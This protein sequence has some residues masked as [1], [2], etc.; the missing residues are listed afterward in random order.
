MTNHAWPPG[1]P[2]PAGQNMAVIPPPST[3]AAMALLA[4]TKTRMAFS[5]ER[6][7]LAFGVPTPA[8]ARTWGV[9]DYLR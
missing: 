9:R 4:L 2:R 3:L 7:S 8:E 1:A 6:I 5:A